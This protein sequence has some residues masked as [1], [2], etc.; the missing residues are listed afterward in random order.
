MEGYPF[1]TIENKWRKS[2]VELKTNSVDIN[3]DKPRK[4]ILVMFSY[5]S[6]K[7]LHIGHWWNYT[8][9]DIYA[10]FMRLSGYNV[11]E[12][13]G[14][15]SFGLPAENFAIKHGV[16]PA[17]ITK[18]SIGLI[19]EQLK[20]I[21][22]MYDWSREIITSSPEYYRWTQWLF[23]KLFE[24]GA[25]YRKKAPVN[26]CPKCMTVLANEQVNPDGSCDRCDAITETRDMDQWLFRITDFADDLLD[27]LDRIDWPESTKA[28]QRHWI[29]RSEGTDI[30]FNIEGKQEV[31]HAFT[32][33]A[34]TLY[35][36]TYV[37]LA[38]ENK[39]VD[40]IIEPDFKTDVNL[41]RKQAKL[42]SDIERMTVDREKTGVFT[43]AYAINPA[44]K[45]KIPIW[46]SDYVL[47]S[48]GTGSV[49]AVPA[50]DQRDFEFASKYDLPIKWVINPASR[51]EEYSKTQAFTDQGIMHSSDQF[52]DLP[53][54]EGILAVSA[55]LENNNQG[56][57]T[58][59]YK[60]RDWSV[61]RQRYWGTPIPIVHCEKCGLVPIPEAELPLILPKEIED[62]KPK[63]TSPLGSIDSFMNVNCPK[64][65][66]DARRDPDTMD[67]FVDSSW[68]FLRYPCNDF[69]NKPFDKD[70]LNRWLPI[71]VYMGGPEH[72][73]G[74]LIYARYI[75]KYLNSLGLLDFDEP[76]KKMI[77]QGII[78][79]NGARMSKSKGNVVN[80]DGFLE[81]YGAD[82]FRLYIMFMGDFTVGGEWSDEGIIGIRRFQNRVWRLINHWIG[83]EIED[84]KQLPEIETEIN[85][86]LNFA[87]KEITGSFE[88]FQFNTPIS[89]L[90]ELINK[91]YS[92]KI[93][94]LDRTFMRGVFDTFTILLSPLAPHMTEELWTILGNAGSVF[95]EKW[96]EWDE[97]ALITDKVKIAVQVCGKF[98]LSVE[99]NKGANQEEAVGCALKLE[100]VKKKISSKEIKRAIFVKDRI[101]NLIV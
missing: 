37:V 100:K 48:Y 40:V 22:A 45:E 87:I 9:T 42:K 44:T 60:L 84:K 93:E 90:M 30:I 54:K 92:V 11:L 14:F 41:Y 5:P 7:K 74:H 64:C 76:A 4:Y 24:T 69:H 99:I 56:K 18:N 19:R 58:V 10:R 29:G 26:W 55:W 12:P 2:W 47:A 53:S 96:P 66:M 28:M 68:Y 97:K 8:G 83:S 77:H 80:P 6:E 21:G 94:N 98:V 95:D 79:L 3:S 32:T 73:T 81:E 89:R 23:L 70:R 86:M 78:S 85:R 36:A 17:K 91:F 1:D 52:N 51:E 72:A 20:K 33:R 61:S 59:T 39:L 75:T 82:C 25:A 67:T 46:I 88:S 35:G 50:H 49:M 13:M 16:H 34:D 57:A 65:G 15:D 38:P 63:G 43:G 31:I 62:F 27:G 71:D 101:L